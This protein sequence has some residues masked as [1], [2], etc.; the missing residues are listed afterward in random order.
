MASQPPPSSPASPTTIASL[1][2]DLLREVFL[3]LPDLPTLVCAASTCR[4]FRAAVR[5]S[6]SFRRSFRALHPPPLL[7]FVLEPFM[8]VIPA[9]S[10][11]WR[12]SDPDL[13]AAFGA[14]DF[15]DTDHLSYQFQGPGWQICSRLCNC[16]GYASA[17]VFSSDTM[18]WQFFPR[19]T[20][21]LREYGTAKAGRV[22]HGLIC[23]ADWMD[24]QIVVLDT[25]TFQFSLMDLPTPLK[26]GESE[27]TTFKL[28]ETKDE[29]LCIVDIKE[30]TLVAWFLTAD[31]D[32]VNE[33]WMMYRTFPLQPIVK[34]FTSC[35][36]EEE[37]HVVVQV[38]AVID[39]FMY[40]SIQNQKDTKPYQL[41]LS[42]CLETAEMKELFRDDG[43][44]YYEEAHPY[45]MAWPSSLVQNK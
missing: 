23:W 6:P 27:E 22:V 11:A 31:D 41:F 4:A 30:N 9:F 42:L 38:E 40:L 12:R 20:L 13:V 14:T 24:D 15:F 32:G 10:S 28:G 8:E 25:A 33:R 44:R 1:R 19:T 3:R 39:G 2:A 17:A 7:A 21:P 34:E 18:E 35:S 45:V 29:K 5:S 43:S 16:D 26:N 36:M 37:G